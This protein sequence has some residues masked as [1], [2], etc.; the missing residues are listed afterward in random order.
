[1]LKLVIDVVIDNKDKI[2][3]PSYVSTVRICGL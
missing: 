2:I 1:M 3:I